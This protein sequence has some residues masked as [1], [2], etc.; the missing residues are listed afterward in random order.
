MAEDFTLIRVKS[1]F[2]KRPQDSDWVTTEK[3]LADKPTMIFYGAMTPWWTHKEEHLS[4]IQ[5]RGKLKIFDKAG[6]VRDVEP[7][8]LPC[9]TRGG[10]L[11]QT[12][13]VRYFLLNAHKHPDVYGRHGVKA[14]ELAHHENRSMALENWEEYNALLDHFLRANKTGLNRLREGFC[15]YCEKVLGLKE[16]ATIWLCS[17]CGFQVTDELKRSMEA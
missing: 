3:V 17:F 5:M 13:K 9:D 2:N 4:K 6:K 1:N 16:R 12:D 11:F 8:G 15:P 10:T 7:T 14:F